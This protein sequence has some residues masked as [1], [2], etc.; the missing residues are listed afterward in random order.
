MED[1]T[2][3][4]AIIKANGLCVCWSQRLKG[5]WGREGGDK[6]EGR[7]KE[8]ERERDKETRQREPE[9]HRWG[10]R[11]ETVEKEDER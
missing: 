2:R 10:K 4:K 11:V 6:G 9:K 1:F 8:R 3:H 7:E 5:V